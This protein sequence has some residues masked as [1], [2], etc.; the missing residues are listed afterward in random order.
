MAAYDRPMSP[1]RFKPG[2]TLG[3]LLGGVATVVTATAIVTAARAQ[4]PLDKSV[5][6]FA[7]R[8]TTGA[9]IV[10]K[11]RYSRKPLT[12][13]ETPTGERSIPRYDNFNFDSRPCAATRP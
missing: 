8:P 12:T 13:L 11:S 2:A 1:K 10:P 7:G 3:F 9:T 6:P 4:A 5:S